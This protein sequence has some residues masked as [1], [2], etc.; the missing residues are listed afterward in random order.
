SLGHVFFY[1]GENDKGLLALGGNQSNQVLIQY[2][3]RSRVTGY[4]WPSSYR[5]P[6]VGAVIVSDPGHIQG[7]EVSGCVW[8]CPR[9]ADRYP[10][11]QRVVA[12]S[13]F[14]NVRKFPHYDVLILRRPGGALSLPNGHCTCSTMRSSNPNTRSYGPQWRSVLTSASL[15][16]ASPGS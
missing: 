4:W 9:F 14:N 6:K 15:S 8:G 2:E 16:C 11:G 12:S 1:L 3:P 10:P 13:N 5:L 7:S